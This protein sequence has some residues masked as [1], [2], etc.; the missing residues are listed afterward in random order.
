MADP[1]YLTTPIYY[2]NDRPHIGHCYT[3]TVADVMARFQRLVRGQGAGG[4]V[5]FLTG[6]DEHADKVVT[7]ATAK[8][9][10]PQDWCDRNAQ[11]FREAFAFMGVSNDDFIR[12]TEARHKDRVPV[13]IE[14]LIKSGEIYKGEFTGWYDESA[15][16]YVPEA[17]AREQQYKAKITG[18]PL[19]KRT[20]PCYFFRL[21]KYQQVLLDH[22]TANPGFIQPDSRRQEVLG[23]LRQGLNDVPVSRPVTDDP[24]TQWG[25]RVPGDPAH[26]VYVW[27]DALFNYLTVVDTPQRRRFWPA[28]VHLIG[29]DILWFHAVIW[30]ALLLALQKSGPDFGW[31]GLPRC[32]FG[33][34]WWV[35]EGQKMSKTLGNFI[36]LEKL[37]AY[38]K[39]APNKEKIPV[40]LDAVRW[41]L[42]TQG[43]L[44]G[45]DADFSHA[46][47]VEVYNADLA[48]GI[49]NCA[50][51]VG[52][53]VEKYF[54]GVLPAQAPG[55]EVGDGFEW[56]SLVR[57]A[58]EKAAAGL[59][60]FD[61]A[62]VLGAPVELIRHVDQYINAT[63]PFKVAKT[64]ETDPGAKERLAA[65]LCN[66]AESV[67]VA[68][69]LASPAM[70][71]KMGQL[72]KTW[73]CEPP[74][75]AT[76]A[77]LCVFG[78]RHSLRAG[79]GIAKGE[80]LFQRANAGDPLPGAAG[81]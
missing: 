6:T 3:T 11:A 59:E 22:I 56:P 63:S 18:R 51:R 60:K 5:F 23:R 53:M 17:A 49:G 77:D 68:S 70:P 30:P 25:I 73:N 40:G 69:V 1:Y 47:F 61:L 10:T 72:W 45:G 31:V 80:I 75:G 32:V 52:N 9:H 12:T 41:Y 67:R 57:A 4:D 74:A 81:D 7:S 71:S 46:K 65:I 14:G 44:S 76:L 28:D 27:I 34:G 79:Q 66:C 62:A 48:N 15:E 43:P 13:Y 78:G 35:S 33:H 64:V 19:L 36:D 39:W 50:S 20:E 58:W 8:G 55:S 38:A 24:A 2:V 16:E 29:K 37:E 21:S 54:G 42:V 26:R